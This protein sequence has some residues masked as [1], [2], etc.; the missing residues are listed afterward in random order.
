MEYGITRRKVGML[1][2]LTVQRMSNQDKIRD[3]ESKQLFVKVT[4]QEKL[5]GCSCVP[6]VS[7]MAEVLLEY[8]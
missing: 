7:A 5:G 2:V 8:H 6:F 1:N 3:L 4:V